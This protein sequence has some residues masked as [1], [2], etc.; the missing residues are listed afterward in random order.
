SYHRLSKVA[1]QSDENFSSALNLAI[2]HINPLSSLQFL[3]ELDLTQNLIED[4]NALGS[5][6]D[7]IYLELSE[8]PIELSRS[9]ENCRKNALSDVVIEFC[10]ALLD[11]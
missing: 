9:N 10:S 1:L 11:E 6:T 4:I 3:S 7:L 8:N 5:H 2:R